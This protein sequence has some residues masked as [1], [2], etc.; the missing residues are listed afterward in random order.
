MP[1]SNYQIKVATKDRFSK[2]LA[3]MSAKQKTFKKELKAT[4]A[5]AKKFSQSEKD[6][7][8][9]TAVKSD[10][11]V[12]GNAIKA[13]RIELKKTGQQVAQ[14]GG[15]MTASMKRQSASQKKN[16]TMLT[17]RYDLQQNKMKALKKVLVSTTGDF[18]N[19]SKSQRV[20]AAKTAVANRKLNEQA[21]HVNKLKRVEG[22]LETRR[23]RNFER[24][25]QRLFKLNKLEEKLQKARGRRNDASMNAAA[26]GA[27]LLAGSKVVKQAANLETA[28]VEVEKKASFKSASGVDLS[29]KKQKNQMA[30]LQNW[31]VTAAPNLGMTPV[32]L[33]QI[34]ASGAGANIARAGKEQQDLQQFSQLAA[35]MSV[36]FD[37][38]SAEDAGKSVAT[39]M[40]SMKL[41]M[42]QSAELASAINH[43]SDNSAANT[44]AVTELMTR[45]GSIMQSA[46]LNHKQA[47]ALGT[48]ILSANGNNMEMGATAAKNM[49]LTLTQ[50]DA[51]SGGQKRTISNLGMNPV[52]LSKDMQ[53]DAVGTIYK[54]IEKIEQKPIHQRNA[55][56][57]TLFG[58]ESIGAINPLITNVEELQ[59][60]M[61]ASSDKVAIRTSLEK[62]F[63]KQQAT[64]NFQ[65]QRLQNSFTAITSAIG[66]ELLP[67]V[68]LG[69]EVLA[70]M[71]NAGTDFI[72][73]N[74]EVAQVVIRA[75]AALAILKTG[76][77]A[78]K[79]ASTA[80]DVVSAKRKLS[81]VKLGGTTNKTAASAIRASAALD[82]LNASMARTGMGGYGPGDT[83]GKGRK[84]RRVR[85]RSKLGK[86]RKLSSKVPVIGSVAAVGLGAYA[87]NDAIQSDSKTKG[88]ETGEI[89]GSIGGSMAGAALG[90]SLG[91]VV[92]IVGTAAG[93]IIGAIAG[94]SLFSY[95]G[96]KAGSQF[97][98][99]SSSPDKNSTAINTV[100]TQ[101][102][103]KQLKAKSLTTY[104]INESD[105]KTH[106]QAINVSNLVNHQFDNRA[107][108]QILKQGQVQKNEIKLD[109]K[110]NIIIHGDSNK[111]EVEQALK[112]SESRVTQS[113]S[114]MM[115]AS[116]SDSIPTY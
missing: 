89:V 14:N 108:R 56:V 7:K 46:G 44:G 47:A 70:D 116:M 12:T 72:H 85:G 74:K 21:Q 40:A 11:L 31:I 78:W 1:G 83:D 76:M 51:M 101:K 80:L 79:V 65:T 41:D 59:R 93:G 48:A 45:S 104:D 110:P 53:T 19:L 55:I 54:L 6:L 102:T 36:A 24:E 8:S 10:M 96:L 100:S 109:Y 68:A 66:K 86:L 5:Q 63:S 81:E 30:Q 37:N 87:L 114:D 61:K 16:L 69:A 82:K 26:A 90:A 43:L 91:S 2:P 95:L 111:K 42:S 18:T 113:L 77:I 98:D 52:Q 13:A 34:V 49:A 112:E 25:K 35:K 50:G 22:Y 64:T 71:M 9:F 97:D 57:S 32:E 4:Q 99:K 107:T 115:D 29:Q 60:V 103:T 62:E 88:A 39:W 15:V 20:L 33:A 58:K 28:M 94:E 3:A 17:A 38:L 67:V 92:P 73:E 106:Q 84:K 27:F 75:A 23:Q 105:Y